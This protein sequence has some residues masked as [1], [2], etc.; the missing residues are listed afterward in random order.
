MAKRGM[1]LAEAVA[2]LVGC[3][4]GAGIFGI[5]YV[6]AKAGILAGIIN[7]VVL[8]TVILFI[9]LYVGEIALRT[10]KTHQL[11][12]YVEKYLGQT[13]KIIMTLSA[14][15]SMVG[16]LIAYIIGEGEVISAIF[17]FN[18]F[19]VSLIFFAIASLVVFFDLEAVKKF[20]LY[21]G[22]VMLALILAICFIS[23]PHVNIANLS[24]FD[25]GQ[26][27]LPY[28]VV[29]FA[30]VGAAAIP[31]ME[32]E[33]RGNKKLMKRAIIIGSLIPF[34]VYLLFMIAVIGVTGAG[35][36]EVATIGL[37][38]AL[39]EYMVL[40]GNLFAIFAM[41][42]SF[43][44]LGLALKWMLHYDYHINK[45]VSWAIACFVPLLIFLAGVRSFIS[46]IAITGAVAG[47][48]EGIL[49][50]LTA[51]MAKKYGDQKPAYSIPLNWFI[52]IIFIAI[53]AFGIAYQFL[54]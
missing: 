10:K 45:T 49:L 21:L 40:L 22:I 32:E 25:L 11:V 48:V 15:F 12:G 53:F 2:T 7:I 47:G 3:I 50:V 54:F 33:L 29:L 18:P 5:P 44:I 6:V 30:F 14:V 39:G 9:N 13:G 19:T 31:E 37:G 52:A 36:T 43:F 16:A 35:T 41:A 8:G 51:K 20:E 24:G 46:V 38:K 23:L 26:I 27:F 34:F 1:A 17:G 42:T 4:I 28:G